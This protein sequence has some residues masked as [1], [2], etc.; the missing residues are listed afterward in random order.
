M[1]SYRRL[2][3]DEIELQNM[4]IVPINEKEAKLASLE[5]QINAKLDAELAA[6]GDDLLWYTQLTKA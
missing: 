4:A 3:T 6:K 5:A 2:K 1:A